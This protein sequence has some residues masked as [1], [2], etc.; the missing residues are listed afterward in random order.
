VTGQGDR[1]AERA[2]APLG[3]VNLVLGRVV[4]GVPFALDGQQAVLDGDL[5]AAKRE[6]ALAFSLLYDSA[7]RSAT[8]PQSTRN[9]SRTP[10]PGQ[11]PALITLGQ[12]VWASNRDERFTAGLNT[13]LAGLRAST[14]GGVAGRPGIV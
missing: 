2:V 9:A 13:L 8:A 10:P 11:F 6:T 3:P 14:E 12:H 1:P 5:Q 7:S 4:G